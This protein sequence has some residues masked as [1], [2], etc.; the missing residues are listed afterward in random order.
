MGFMAFLAILFVM[1]WL[2][3]GILLIVWLYKQLSAKYFFP[4]P[5]KPAA[6]EYPALAGEPEKVFTLIPIVTPDGQPLHLT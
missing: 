6:R 3:A 2:I 1:V 5:G 4:W